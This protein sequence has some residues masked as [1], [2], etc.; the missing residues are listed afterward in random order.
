MEPALI[1]K[2]GLAVG[3]I[4]AILVSACARA[5]RRAFPTADLRAMVFSALVLYGVGL[6]AALTNH[7]VVAAAVYTCGIA[8]SAFAAWLSR[9]SDSADPGG[10]GSARKGPPPSEP[11]PGF[12][13]ASFERQF[14]DYSRRND[15]PPVATH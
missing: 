13:W 6:A 3:L 7:A 15:R 14:R 4:A 8:V 9:G 1:W 11:G 12:D 2:L 10:G 5:P